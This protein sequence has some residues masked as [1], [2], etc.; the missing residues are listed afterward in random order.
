MR[1]KHISVAA[2]MI[3][4]AAFFLFAGCDGCSVRSDLDGKWTSTSE[5]ETKIS[6]SS[7]GKVIMTGEG[8]T[9]SGTY[10]TDGDKLSM[11]LTAPNDTVLEIDATY[12]VDGNRLSL[13][14]ELGYTE[15]FT[16]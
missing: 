14:N 15:V 13:K 2:L 11:K 9:L 8:I 1:R 3:M 5:T 10:S 7:T 4:L 16:K 12:E 6:F